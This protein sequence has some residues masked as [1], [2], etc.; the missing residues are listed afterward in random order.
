[1]RPRVCGRRAPRLLGTRE[2]TAS[3]WFHPFERTD[4]LNVRLET[5]P[6][7]APDD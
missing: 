3:A 5:K 1:V 6:S 4:V 7:A 2:G